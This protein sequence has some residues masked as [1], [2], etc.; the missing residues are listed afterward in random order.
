VAA[1]VKDTAWFN[2]EAGRVNLAG[3]Y[4]LSLNLDPTLCKDYPVKSSRNDHLIPFNLALDASLPAQ[5]QPGTGND[6]P[7]DL[8]VQPERAR[9]LEGALSAD[10]LIEEADPLLRIRWVVVRS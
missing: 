6:V 4:T 9:D 3:D 7:L 8:G 5:Q 1:P 2:E 10:A